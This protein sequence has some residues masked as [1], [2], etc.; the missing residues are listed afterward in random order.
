MQDLPASDSGM[1]SN[2]TG[3]WPA[4]ISYLFV[5]SLI[6]YF[7]FPS[8]P[9][10]RFHA[11][12]GVVL[13]IVEIC[14]LFI[15]WILDHTLGRIPFLGILISIAIRMILSLP[16]LALLILGFTRAMSGEKT[17][18]PWIGHWADQLPEPHGRGEKVT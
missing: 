6:Q 14:A 8:R 9:Y 1:E 18:L 2:K 17:P 4:A 10:I 5:I 12:Q 11:R 7:L 3:R 16:L 13:C 15:S